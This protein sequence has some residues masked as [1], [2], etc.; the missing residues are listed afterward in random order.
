VPGTPYAEWPQRLLAWLIDSAPVLVLVLIAEV[1]GSS[2]LIL[3]AVLAGL[4][5]AVYNYGMQQ[6]ETGYSLGKGIVGIKL[7]SEPTG[8][9]VG[10]GMAIAR[11]FVH[12]LDAIPC[13]IGY[14]WPL[15]DAKKQ[16]FADKILSQV[17][18]VA[19]K[20]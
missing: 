19:P 16:T 18:V 15:W 5:W 6:G 9:P 10:T 14:L 1:T 2:A 3:I 7:I 8:Q 20:Q 12:V 17:V 4:A 13:Y 11:Y